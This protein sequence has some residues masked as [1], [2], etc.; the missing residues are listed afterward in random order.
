[1][2]KKQP[3]TLIIGG[4]CSVCGE[5]GGNAF[6]DE[7][8]HETMAPGGKG[9]GVEWRYVTNDN[10]GHVTPEDAKR[11]RP[12]LEWRENTERRP[13]AKSMERALISGANPWPDHRNN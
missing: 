6:W 13:V 11:M 1:M 9:C 2:G 4:F 10:D 7:K 8:K 12:D 5:C 3:K